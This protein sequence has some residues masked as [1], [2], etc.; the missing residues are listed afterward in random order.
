LDDD[1]NGLASEMGRDVVQLWTGGVEPHGLDRHA[2]VLEQVEQRGEARALNEYEVP[3]PQQCAG[4]QVEG[5]H[6]AVDHE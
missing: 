6:G 2:P 1:G 5:I 3:R 4:H